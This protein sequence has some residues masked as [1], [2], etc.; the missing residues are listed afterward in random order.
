MVV[1]TEGEGEAD[2]LSVVRFTV[3]VGEGVADTVS[4]PEMQAVEDP[5]EPTPLTVS[6]AVGVEEKL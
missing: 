2:T 4:V 6:V 3:P 1:D 5:T